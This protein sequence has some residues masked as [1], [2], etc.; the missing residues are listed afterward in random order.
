VGAPWCKTQRQKVGFVLCADAGAV[1][2]DKQT[3]GHP[4]QMQAFSAPMSKPDIK[5]R[6]AEDAQHPVPTV[7]ALKWMRMAHS[8][9][10]TP[11]T[12]SG[13]YRA[14]RV[15]HGAHPESTAQLPG[16]CTEHS[17]ACFC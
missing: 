15:P 1:A 2:V 12:K 11:S 13:R 3:H 9:C 14:L 16:G 8:S 5:G 7:N 4:T 10:S 6:R 17:F